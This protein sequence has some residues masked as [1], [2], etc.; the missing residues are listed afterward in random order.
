MYMHTT[1][2]NTTR[3]PEQAMDASFTPEI[4]ETPRVGQSAIPLAQPAL[5][6]H[7]GRFGSGDKTDK[8]SPTKNRQPSFKRVAW[9]LAIALAVIGGGKLVDDWWTVGRFMESTDD[10]Y[11]GGDAHVVSFAPATGSQFSVLPVENATGNF[12]K[13]V[14]RVTV[15]I[16]LDDEAATLGQLRPGLSVTVKVNTLPKVGS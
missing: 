16:Q 5:V 10:A 1:S 4:N 13:I 12:T 2:S 6:N 7:A 9:V 8:V 15:R 14:Q 11:I 3:E